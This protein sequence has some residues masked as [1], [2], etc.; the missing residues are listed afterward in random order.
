[1][2]LPDLPTNW[3]WPF[4]GK[5][6]G[7][8]RGQSGGTDLEDVNGDYPNVPILNAVAP[9]EMAYSSS[10]S[11]FDLS[12]A[13]SALIPSVPTGGT[14]Y[15]DAING[16]DTTGKIGERTLPY[17]TLS[18]ALSAI[19]LLGPSP[20]NTFLCQI[21]PGA[22]TEDNPIALLSG[23]TVTSSDGPGT[24]TILPQDPAAPIFIGTADAVIKGV[25]MAGA[26]DAG[27]FG[28]RYTDLVSNPPG[29]LNVSDCIVEDCETGLQQEGSGAFVSLTR[30]RFIKGGSM[31]V[32]VSSVGA[33]PANGSGIF[34]LMTE[35]TGNPGDNLSRAVLSDG[36]FVRFGAQVI[37]GFSDSGL[38]TENGGIIVGTDIVFS[39]TT[40]PFHISPSSGIISVGTFAIIGDGVIKIESST[41]QLITGSGVHSAEPEVVAGAGWF[42]LT[43][44]EAQR[45]AVIEGSLRVGSAGRPA[46]TS[47]GSGGIHTSGLRAWQNDAI[48]A[49]TFADVTDDVISASGSSLDLLPGVGVGNS[50]F[51]GSDQPL[52]GCFFD[53]TL[54]QSGGTIVPK[55]WNGAAW[56]AI[57]RWMT[58]GALTPFDPAA[59]AL[60]AATGKQDL[61]FSALPGDTAKAVNGV[62]KYWYLWE[63]TSGL[64]TS[65]RIEQAKLHTSH[66][67]FAE[68]G[69]ALHYGD[70]RPTRSVEMDLA[71]WRAGASGAPNNATVAYSANISRLS[72]GGFQNS[73]VKD[74]AYDWSV[75]PDLDTSDQPVL[76]V[77]VY[78]STAGGGN[79]LIDFFYVP[80]PVS[81]PPLLLNGALPGEVTDTRQIAMGTTAGQTQVISYPLSLEALVAGTDRVA[82]ELQRRG[83]DGLDTFGGVFVVTK[84]TLYYRAWRD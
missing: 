83:G 77:E 39:T 79:A 80:I 20:S 7:L 52:P 40:Y 66:T 53:V 61:R 44:N 26:S 27:G 58:A 47:L 24:V 84:A 68:S 30:T 32:A 1:M 43:F 22:Y 18:A 54:A 49:G 67:R 34:V 76:D 75:P 73:L 51:L 6:L 82:H 5:L 15:V 23:V 50:F 41:G 4:T 57:P 29:R 19:Q 64:T 10:Q 13:A 48:E 71:L 21:H 31:T 28:L 25:R 56:T 36:S 3:L 33:S 55:Y 60:F 42:G 59:N 70:S 45:T 12:I 62:V 14:A 74:L 46:V 69:R 78:P 16:S 72:P 11:R 35:I 81:A 65:P 63:V 2:P 9:L 38:Y 8:W 17:Q 37:V